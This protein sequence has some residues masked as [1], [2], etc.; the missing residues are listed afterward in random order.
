M[1]RIKTV[2]T[3]PLWETLLITAAIVSI[4]STSIILFESS[5]HVPLV[6]SLLLLCIYGI[7]KG[8]PYKTLEEG[9]IEGA[10][11]GMGAV[12]IFFFIGVLIATWMLGG[13]IPTLMYSGL[14][15]VTP[16]FYFAV[17]FIITSVIG[18][19]V[20]SSLTTVAT[21]GVAFIGISEAVDVSLAI[22]AGAIVSGSFLEIK[23]PHC[24]IQRIWLHLF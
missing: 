9:I 3:P 11:S 23:C 14:E 15:L 18:I 24:Q 8:V 6:I 1:Y 12:F 21:V 4:I 13:T 19:A 17:V 10:K 5:P 16:S 20:G 22:T 7:A 2:Q